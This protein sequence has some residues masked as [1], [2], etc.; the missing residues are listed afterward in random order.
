MPQIVHEYGKFQAKILDHLIM[1]ISSKLFVVF[2]L[3][4][5]TCNFDKQEL[6][7]NNQNR[8]LNTTATWFPTT[9]QKI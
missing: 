5:E 7:H 1:I 6:R 3:D 4:G 2:D 8:C 9:V